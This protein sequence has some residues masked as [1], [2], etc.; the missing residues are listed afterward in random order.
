MKKR[1]I[2]TNNLSQFQEICILILS[3][4]I[5]DFK[6]VRN[7]IYQAEHFDRSDIKTK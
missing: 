6:I 5:G 2:S 3:T 7:T 1:N 4:H